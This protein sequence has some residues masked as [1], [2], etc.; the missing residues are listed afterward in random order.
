MVTRHWAYVRTHGADTNGDDLS[1]ASSKEFFKKKEKNI[2]VGVQETWGISATKQG[3]HRHPPGGEGERG[4][5]NVLGSPRF[6][7]FLG[8]PQHTVA[9]SF[10][11][12]LRCIHWHLLGSREVTPIPIICLFIV[13]SFASSNKKFSGGTTGA[14]VSAEEKKKQGRQMRATLAAGEHQTSRAF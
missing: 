14:G 7:G 9:C 6:S 13:V 1:S 11:S 12:F 3:R 5:P 2:F 8:S 10:V 4:R